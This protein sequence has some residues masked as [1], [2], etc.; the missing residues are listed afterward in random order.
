MGLE[1][2]ESQLQTAATTPRQG[3]DFRL[4]RMISTVREIEAR[5][6]LIAE[7]K[8]RP[9]VSSPT[10]LVDAV[11]A[12]IQAGADTVAICTDAEATP[13]GLAD[14]FA[15]CR[16]VSQP[17]VARDWYLHPIQVVDAR[18][19]GA[20]SVLGIVDSVTGP[21]SAVLSSFASALGLEAPVEVVNKQQS[22]AAEAGG[23]PFIAV[24]VGVSLSIS[25][26]SITAQIAH[27]LI[28]DQPFGNQ[29]IMGVRSLD[30]VRQA[31]A[32]RADCIFIGEA[33]YDANAQLLQ[34]RMAEDAPFTVRREA[35]LEEVLDIL[36]T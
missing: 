36:T 35:C 9:G 10:E 13:Q 19:A 20:A 18:E 21:G 1:A 17:V 12:A 14:L 26:P 2:L 22:D 31:K 11:K 8:R 32:S 34:K 16:A 33:F 4:T 29:T 24:S 27:A 15:V 25:M 30:E 6:L 23:I 5:P 7:V 3:P 28:T